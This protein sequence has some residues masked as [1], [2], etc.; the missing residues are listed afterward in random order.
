MN[1]K[2]RK[3]E[4][5]KERKK[6]G[7]IVSIEKRLKLRKREKSKEESKVEEIKYG[8]ELKEVEIGNN[9]IEYKKVIRIED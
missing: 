2:R 5:G 1:I 9:N 7:K 4:R 6:G 8:G 3:K